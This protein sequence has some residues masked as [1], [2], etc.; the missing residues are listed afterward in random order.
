MICKGFVQLSNARALIGQV[1]KGMA[2]A[3]K[4]FVPHYDDPLGAASEKRC[5][6]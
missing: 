3:R 5:F 4:R 2:K 6:E 1:T